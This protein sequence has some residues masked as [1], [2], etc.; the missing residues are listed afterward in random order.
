MNTLFVKRC[1]RIGNQ[2]VRFCIERPFWTS[3]EEIAN[4]RATTPSALVTSIVSDRDGASLPSTIRAFVIDHFRKRM[5][6]L[7]DG[8]DCESDAARSS[9]DGERAAPYRPRWLN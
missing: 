3:L 8:H 9:G 6:Q 2:E 1:L 5:R 4:T 7:D